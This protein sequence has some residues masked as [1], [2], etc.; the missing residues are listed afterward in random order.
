MD[1]T[2][3]DCAERFDNEN[4]QS[5]E[6]TKTVLFLKLSIKDSLRLMIL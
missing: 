4:K 1:A 5:I 3:E 2:S 6:S